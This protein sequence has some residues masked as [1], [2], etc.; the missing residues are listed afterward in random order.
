MKLYSY[1][2][3]RDFGFAPNPFNGY[4][5]LA[6]CK[7]K[8]RSAASVG[9]WI[10][11]TG[12]K[13]IYKRAGQLIY[14]MQVDEFMDY[15][16]YWK[17]SRFACKR[18]VLN[19]SLKQIYGDNIYHR[20]RSEWIQTNSHHSLDNGRP[21]PKNVNH[22]TSVNRLLISRKF[23]FFGEEA[24]VIPKQF[25]PYSP[26]GE[27]ICC[28]TQGHRVLSDALAKAFARWLE[29]AGRWGVIGMPLEFSG[30]M[31]TFSRSMNT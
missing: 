20:H 10:V 17:D 1:I 25:R 8:I 30:H 2:V 16:H 6:T 22:D 4:C 19:G 14:A 3:A 27:D 18:P 9:D 29:D 28:A 15:D 24:P 31:R 11:G 23:V 21:N 13:T 26:T 5:T 7:P 12:A